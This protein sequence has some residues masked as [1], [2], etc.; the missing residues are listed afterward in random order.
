MDKLFIFTQ[1]K[2]LN[3]EKKSLFKRLL[4][5]G[6]TNYHVILTNI[7]FNRQNI[8]KKRHL[9]KDLNFPNSKVLNNL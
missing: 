1:G 3:L 5:Y 8:N 7:Y 4:I 6:G 9:G 2:Y